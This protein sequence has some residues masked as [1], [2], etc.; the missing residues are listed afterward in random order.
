[1]ANTTKVQRKLL[2]FIENTIVYGI[3]ILIAIIVI[4][5]VVWI[6]LSSFQQ[7]TS[8]Y[9]STFIPKK[10]TLVH[11]KELFTKTDFP[12]WYMNTLKIAFFNMIIGV[13]VTT[14]TAY[15][16]SRYRFRGRK[17]MMIGML[18]LQ[19]FPSFLSMTAIFV[20]LTK[21]QLVDS[22]WGLIIVYAAGQ[23]PYNAWLVKGYFEGIP[24]S[25]DEAARVDGAGH[26]TIFWKIIMPLARP[27]LVL[28]ALTNFTGPW[29]DF[30][31]P[32]LI[33]R[34]RFKKTLA[35]GIFEWVQGRADNNFTLFAAGS[36]LV[37]IPI[38]ILFVFLQKNIVEGLSQG[39]TKG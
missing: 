27:I 18:I 22:H 36:L 37:A 33:L 28:I 3:L 32:K 31:F 19:M 6:V 25:L 1:M 26:L 11:Y 7:G 21:L 2:R 38:L 13:I 24:K 9:S 39:A 34:S 15:T 16:F 17:E 29:F 20:L 35:V 5:P 10:L 4:L 8:L 30:I 14:L 23:I 12:I